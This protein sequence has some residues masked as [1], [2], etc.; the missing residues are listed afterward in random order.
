MRSSRAAL[1]GSVVIQLGP[2]IWAACSNIFASPCRRGGGIESWTQLRGTDPFRP[3]PLRD[4]GRDLQ[5]KPRGRG[6]AGST[7]G[8]PV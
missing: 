2:V 3:H 7:A 8:P 4:P 1:I 6:V 5:L